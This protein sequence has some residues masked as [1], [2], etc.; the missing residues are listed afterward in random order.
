M[1][2]VRVGIRPPS[3]L[4]PREAEVVTIGENTMEAMLADTPLGKVV[5]AGALETGNE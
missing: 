4:H 2:R 1:R 3:S 5:V